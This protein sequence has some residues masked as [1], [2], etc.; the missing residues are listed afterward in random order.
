MTTP[1]T[2]AGWYPDPEQS[3][4]LR[5]W[6]GGSWTE[7]LHPRAG[8]ALVCSPRTPRRPAKRRPRAG[9]TRRHRAR[10]RPSRPEPPEPEPPARARAG[11]RHR[12]SRR[13]GCRCA[14]RLPS[15][16]RSRRPN[17][18]RYRSP[19][20]R[21]R[22]AAARAVHRT[23][24]PPRRRRPS[25]RPSNHRQ[26]PSRRPR[27]TTATWS[28]GSAAPSPHC[29]WSLVLVAVYAFVIHKDDTV[30]IS[31][32]TTTE[33]SATTTEDETTTS[34]EATATEPPTATA[35]G[36]RPTARWSSRSSAS[37][38]VPPSPTRR[39]SS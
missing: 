29:C 22:S 30:Q 35:P 4:G 24:T 36:G 11:A 28:C 15:P 34:E 9:P 32:P 16:L 1:P 2:P 12:R 33:S 13:P 37:R 27:S 31:A 7:H 14:I 20:S 17:R 10:G 39:T 38:A 23:R 25:H 26:A 8:A 3:G 21:R 18:R 19:S 6:D 5:Y